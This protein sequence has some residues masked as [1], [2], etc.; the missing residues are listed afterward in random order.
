M[1]LGKLGPLVD[2][3][4]GYKDDRRLERLT[5]SRGFLSDLTDRWVRQMDTE[6]DLNI[7]FYWGAGSV[8]KR[9]CLQ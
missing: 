1:L 6:L 7:V 9:K 5:D 3:A 8:P 2:L 4:R